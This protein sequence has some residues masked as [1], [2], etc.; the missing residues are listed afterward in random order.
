MS[1][2]DD[3]AGMVKQLLVHRVTLPIEEEEQAACAEAV[4]R[5]TTVLPREAIRRASISKKSVDARHRD[6]LCF[7]YS[8]LVEVELPKRFL[9]NPAQTAELLQRRANAVF[10]R[11]ADVTP[12]LG[13]EKMQGRPIVVGFGPAGMFGALL[14]AEQGYR[15]IV[16]ERGGDVWERVDAVERFYRSGDLDSDTNIQFG[17]GGAGTFSDGKLM[18]RVNDPLCR[19]VLR[20]FVSF[21][22]PESI[23]TAAKPH[24]GTDLLR[25]VVANLRDRITACGGTVL[26]HTRME[27]MLAGGRGIRAVRTTAGDFA[28]GALLL[29]IGH[30]ARDTYRS[31][32]RAGFDIVPKPFSVGVRIEHLQSEIDRALYGS[33]AGHPALGHAEYALSMRRGN[34]AVYSFCMCPGGE[35]VAA[36]SEQGGVV[37]NGMSRHARDGQNANAALAVSVESSDPIAYQRHLE[38]AA[39]SAGGGGY[40]APLQ[41]VGDFL[42]H[43]HGTKPG[44]VHSSYMGGDHYT[45]CDLHAILPP[46]VCSML[47][48][49]IADFSEKIAGFDAPE[50]LLTG[51]ETRTSAPV[52]IQRGEMLTATGYDNLYPC[53]EGAGY[54][55]GITSAALDGIRCAMAMMKRYRPADDKD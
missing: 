6:R 7:V 40:Y 49:G 48:A 33:F 37:V 24:I 35:V 43:G 12:V 4:A 23:L 34:R 11:E 1:R 53:G 44:A 16:L 52:R 21:G 9:R 55:G 15:P 45:L 28:C 8:V 20:R 26:F 50:A 17:A 18:T 27:E 13:D 22:A 14:L 30:S 38:Q 32:M 46:D 54:A 47:E 51:V 19:Y 2:N 25:S 36:A 5:L 3:N 10:Y 42:S 31:M 39:F 29:A 41:T